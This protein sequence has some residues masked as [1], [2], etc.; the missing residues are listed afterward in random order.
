MSEID[1]LRK[2]A[3]RMRRPPEEEQPMT[4]PMPMT[5]LGVPAPSLE[6]PAEPA[7]LPIGGEPAPAP[8]NTVGEQDLIKANR[9]LSKYQA[10]KSSVENRV[11]A[12]EQWWKLRQWDYLDE[13]GNRDADRPAS[14]W[15][16]NCIIS[17]HADGIEAYPEPNIL[18][19]EAGDKPEAKMLSSIMPV[20]LDQVDFQSTYSD[21][22]WQKLKQ[23]TGIYG[24][25]W[26]KDKHNGLGDINITKIDA[27]SIYWEPGISDI[28][29][30]RN[31]FT[32]ELVDVDLL[33]D[34]Y[35]DELM[36]ETVVGK[37]F[38]PSKYIYDD[39]VDVE[40]K[41][42]VVDWYYRRTVNGRRVLHY[43]KYVDT[44]V[45]YATENDPEYAER[46]LYD[47]GLYPFVFDTQFPIEGS[48][49]G[50]GY[51]DVGRGPQGD[52]DRL[53]QAIIMNAIMSATPRWFV[54][55]NHSINLD[56]FTD[57]RNPFV[58]VAGGTLG[59]DDIRG[60]QVDQIPA[61]AIQ[62]MQ[63]K[64]Q[65]LKETTGNR[66]AN[67]GGSAPGVTAASAIAA[68][69]EQ[70]GK[71]SRA[72]TLSAYRAYREIVNMCIELIRQFYDMPRAF[73]IIGEAG[74]EEYVQYTNAGIAPMLQE[75][76][77]EEMGTRIPAFD[78]D[79]S[80]QK[81]N[82]Y[83][84][85]TQN[86][87]A[88]QFY[89]LGLLNP[90]NADQSLAVLDIMDFQ[91]KDLIEEK[92][93][94]NGTMYQMLAQYQQMLLTLA[95]RMGDPGLMEMVAANIQQVQAELGG[96]APDA[97]ADVNLSTADPTA[98]RPERAGGLMDKA[99]ARSQST[100]QPDA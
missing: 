40:D 44:T 20:V 18:P 41:A 62:V 3:Q 84:K 24:V 91:H 35:P 1:R 38:T 80:A 70:A 48:P 9:L 28:Q 64:V 2:N 13:H 94:K 78:V 60:I 43:V 16:F 95:A 52:I 12:C 42:V 55:A 98:G 32:V 72:S 74:A 26:D 93:R 71:T 14:A 30:S 67:T 83:T 87:L 58:R 69:Q 45:L 59:E 5:P 81:M 10:G 89:Q 53:N 97:R 88:L 7:H 36:N 99:R 27:L 4:P 92:V 37:A 86:E 66:D 50:Y 96:V 31:V 76:A 100:T 47:H 90:Q 25:F 17:K 65:E 79:V 61:I 34:M 39:H 63:D 82:A 6:I 22:L 33:R 49:C 54:K 73:R 19:R 29:K 57:W 46:G 8:L 56:D 75:T 23:G 51:I 15:L 68:M 77:G 11:I 21:V 85:V